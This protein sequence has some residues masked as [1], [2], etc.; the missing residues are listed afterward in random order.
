MAES[1]TSRTV[2]GGVEGSIFSLKVIIRAAFYFSEF[3]PTWPR[4]RVSETDFRLVQLDHRPLEVEVDYILKHMLENESKSHDQER[5]RY[6][7][8]KATIP[9]EL[10]CAGK[11]PMRTAT[12]EIS[13]CGCYIEMMFTIEVGTKLELV[14]SLNQERVGAMGLVVT[15][16]PQV[17][18]GIDFIDMEP[19]NRLRLGEY[20]AERER[21]TTATEATNLE[22]TTG[23]K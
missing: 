4:V 20:I 9:V 11:S 14:F 1:S 23:S 17:G 16:H 21:E 7:R 2:S 15:K 18:N 8:V 12:D 19:K 3:N 6:P 5:R 10:I 22:H 13:L